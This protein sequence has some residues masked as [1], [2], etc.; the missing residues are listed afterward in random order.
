[1]STVTLDQPA[2]QVFNTTKP[3]RRAT[4]KP[5]VVKE[6]VPVEEKKTEVVEEKK[7]EEAPVAKT[8]GR[9]GRVVKNTAPESEPAPA[10]KRTNR[11]QPVVQNDGEEQSTAKKTAPTRRTV[12]NKDKKKKEEPKSSVALKLV[13]DLHTLLTDRSIDANGKKSVEKEI[14]AA[15]NDYNNRDIIDSLRSLYELV[16]SA[17]WNTTKKKPHSVSDEVYNFLGAANW[18][19]A[20]SKANIKGKVHYTALEK[21]LN[22]SLYCVN[23]GIVNTVILNQLAKLYVL[24][25]PDIKVPLPE[26]EKRTPQSFT[27]AADE[28]MN[29]HLASIMDA[30]AEA[31]EEYNRKVDESNNAKKKHKVVFDSENIPRQ[32]FSKIFQYQWEDYQ[33]EDE[34]E[35]IEGL[36]ADEKLLSDTIQYYERQKSG[37]ATK[38]N[39]EA[40]AEDEEEVADEE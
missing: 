15:E 28:L 24:L 17:T 9:R 27:I 33:G 10:P 22:D 35:V 1:M 25:N 32:Q 37:K 30:L 31:D 23:A 4:N 29:K 14:I 6:E 18:G 5:P 16:F 13:A 39:D 34:A 7:I 2:E 12:A 3:R 11:R 20:Y 40:E 38:A 26:G 21:N 36:A 19:P 8:T